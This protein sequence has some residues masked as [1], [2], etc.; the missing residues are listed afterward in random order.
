MENNINIDLLVLT[1]I[2]LD[3]NSIQIIDIDLGVNI[4]VNLEMN[5]GI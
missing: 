1:E 5:D 4:V 3:L 2:H